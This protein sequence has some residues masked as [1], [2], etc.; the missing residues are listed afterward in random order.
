MTLRDRLTP[1]T[2]VGRITGLVVTAVLLGIALTTIAFVMFF[3]SESR[4][5]PEMI[6][7]ARSAR[8]ALIVRQAETTPDSDKLDQM[9]RMIRLFGMSVESVSL[10]Q[11]TTTPGDSGADQSGFAAS[12]AR[13]LHDVWGISPIPGARFPTYRDAVIVKVSNDDA[14]VFADAGGRVV[15][16]LVLV[17][18]L[19]ATTIIA[20]VLLLLSVFGVRWVAAPLM[21]I[22][23]AARSFGRSSGESAPLREEGPREIVQVAAALNEMRV[24]VRSLVDDRTRMLTAI[25]HDLRT[26][27]TRLR[28][29]A[30]RVGDAKM[31][32]SMLNDITT[33]NDMLNETL[34]YLR[35]NGR[36]EKVGLIDLPSLLQTIGAQFTDVGRPVSYEG[37][38]RLPIVCRERA[39]TRAIANIVDNATKHGTTV[40][41]RLWSLDAGVVGIDVSDDGPGIPHGLRE[42]VF[43]PFF[44]GDSARSGVKSAGFG[45]GLSIA[46]DIVEGHGG[47]ITLT[48]H[49]P[50]GLTV[51]VTLPTGGPA[52]DP[53]R[54]IS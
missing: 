47:A 49:L 19:V 35:E 53:A 8:I 13:P 32:D 16:L 31:R 9:I 26:P 27:L 24:R 12:V 54:N 5:N 18:T 50:T 34:S 17:P 2:I 30:E 15:R 11:L 10:S 7:A 52:G 6:A 40:V 46:R 44:K 43:D 29:R 3:E 21:S 48:D 42:K 41:V 14:L 20:L 25:S 22:A 37:P 28:L 38:G 23:H 51:R 4:N 36:V 39:L 45:L 1:K 33:I